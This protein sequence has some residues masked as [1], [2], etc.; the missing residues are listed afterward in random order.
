MASPTSKTA[1]ASMRSVAGAK[2]AFIASADV[3]VIVPLG[4][5]DWC[6]VRSAQG[7]TMK[8]RTSSEEFL[9]LIL[10]RCAGGAE[11]KVRSE[12]EVLAG[13]DERWVPA[14]DALTTALTAAQDASE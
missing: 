8:V 7:R 5:P 10:E 6:Y 3:P 4:P 2:D 1:R 12:L 14:R 13:T 9:T 11:A